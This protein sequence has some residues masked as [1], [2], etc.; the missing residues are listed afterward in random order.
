MFKNLNGRCQ[1]LVGRR[2][3]RQWWPVLF[4]PAGMFLVYLA[5]MT[6]QEW[7]V[8]RGA[9]E[10][11]ALGMVGVCVVGFGLQVI[12][13]R[14]EF[15]LF[16]LALCASFFCREWH[17]PGTSKGIYI[18]L[19]VLALWAVIRKDKLAIIRD[20]RLKIWLWATFGT[21]LLSQLI[22][23]RVF[24]Y[25]YLPQEANLHIFLEETVETV[26]HM[27]MIVT[28]FVT[29]RA[30]VRVKAANTE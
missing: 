27:M 17:F 13:F 2:Q 21:Y 25:V 10:G 24:R 8:S 19:V 1:S 22:A 26:A 29:W 4:G 14:C 7:L 23:R 20:N 9:N 6:G 5:K 11:I 18:A 28:C 15:H 3:Y 16:M 30:V 12:I